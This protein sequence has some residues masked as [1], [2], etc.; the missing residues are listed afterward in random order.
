MLLTLIHSYRMLLEYEM[1]VF[2]QAARF[3]PHFPSAAR[4]RFIPPFHTPVSYPRFIPLCGSAF[5]TPV[6]YPRFIPLASLKRLILKYCFIPPFD[7]PRFIPRFM[8]PFHAPVSYPRFIP[9][10]RGDAFHTPKKNR[11]IK[12]PKILSYPDTLH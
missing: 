1:A 12:P 11:A 2:F 7:T 3:I 6:S 8:P 4:P 5:H 10:L 9:P